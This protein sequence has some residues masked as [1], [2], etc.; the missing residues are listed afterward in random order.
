MTRSEEAKAPTLEEILRAKIEDARLPAFIRN[1]FA[2]SLAAWE[3]E[4]DKSLRS[5]LSRLA[6]AAG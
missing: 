2:R 6:R 4:K 3:K 1:H 5:Q